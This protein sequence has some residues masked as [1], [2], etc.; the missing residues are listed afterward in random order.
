M[1]DL[2]SA[3]VDAGSPFGAPTTDDLERAHALA[4]MKRFATA[5]LVM[6]GVVFIVI[7]AID[8]AGA[9]AGYVRAVAEAAMVGAIADWFAVTAL[10][11]HPLGL[12]IP[13]TAIIP[14]RK[15]DIGK[16]LGDFVESN[17]LTTEVIDQRLRGAEIGK[18]AGTWLAD[19]IHAERAV[20]ALADVL[21]GALEVLDD[22]EIQLGIEHVVQSRIDAVDPA[23]LLGKVLEATVEGGH[24]QRLLDAV[25]VGL[26]GFMA[27]NR[28]TFQRRIYEESPWWVPEGIDNRVLDKIYTAVGRFMTDIAASPHHEV[29]RTVDQRAREFAARLHDDPA[30]TAKGDELKAELLAHPEVRSWI[31]SLWGQAKQALL[32]ASDDKDSELRQRVTRSLQQLGTRLATEPELQAKVD[33]WVSQAVA[34]LVANYRTEVSDIISSTVAK[35]DAD[36]TAEKIELQVGRDLQFIRINGTVVGGLAGLVI[37]AVGQLF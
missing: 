15:D 21:R 5:L 30:L 4:R 10:F 29:R 13:H 27:D 25:L 28:D 16:S 12:P 32:S 6:A 18:R 24:H 9:W 11:R 31:D 22:T 35:W 14:T 26:S 20:D 2:L 34:H 17:F 23:P 1:S 7:T 37:H 36:A 33:A 8:P 19:D 3:P